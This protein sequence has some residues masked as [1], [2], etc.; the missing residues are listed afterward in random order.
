MAQAFTQ[1]AW[2]DGQAPS[3]AAVQLNRIESGIYLASAPVVSSLPSSPVDG[4]EC[5]YLADATNGVVWHL[6]YRSASGKWHMTGGPGLFSQVLSFPNLNQS[7][8]FDWTGPAIT[9]PLLGDYQVELGMRP[10]KVDG[11]KFSIWM[12]FTVGATAASDTDAVQASHDQDTADS[13]MRTLTKTAV[14]AGSLLSSRMRNSGGV[15][16]VNNAWMRV[17]PIR[18]G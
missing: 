3:V 9:V 16:S 14:P 17:T 11:T 7:A 10:Y 2:L 13:V 18:I 1:T 8:Y 4:Q 5:N 15:W 6:I 12:S